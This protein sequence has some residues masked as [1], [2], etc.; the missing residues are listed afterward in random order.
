VSSHSYRVRRGDTLSGIAARAGVSV[1]YLAALNHIRRPG[2]IFV[3]SKLTLPGGGGGAP[4]SPGAPSMVL[5]SAR[6]YAVQPGD[7][8]SGIA[9]RAGVSLRALAALNRINPRGVLFAGATLTLPAGSQPVG[10]PT[11]GGGDAP[12]YPTPER[13]TAAEVE[14]IA[15]DN[16]V[17]GSLAAAIGWQESGFN[18]DFVSSANARGVMQ[19]LPKT[20]RWIGRNLS[21]GTPLS[22]AS[23]LDN[24]RAGVLF[25]HSLLNATDGNAALAVAG[26][27]Q[28][29]SSVRRR[30]MYAE[31]RQYVR[32]VLSLR[33]TFGGP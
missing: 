30:G 24:V 33:R 3:G 11:A 4:S 17:P 7:T 29:L 18:N 15:A 14:Q 13:V 6:S 8:L 31:T 2:L 12:P 21:A 1:R 10:P 26:Y 27:I 22:P 19:I 28:G 32:D 20:W 16:G 5:A 25:L 23:A 9:L